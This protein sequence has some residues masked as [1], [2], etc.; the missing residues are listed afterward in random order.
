MI[1]F[2]KMIYHSQSL[3]SLSSSSWWIVDTLRNDIQ[4]LF[5][6]RLVHPPVDFVS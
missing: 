3:D 5:V 1:D 2:I 6:V 4:V